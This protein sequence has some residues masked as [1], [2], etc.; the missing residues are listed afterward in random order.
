MEAGRLRPVA[1]RL[2]FEDF[3]AAH[4]PE[5]VRGLFLLTAS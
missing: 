5:L 2:E 4:Y 1:A 3:F